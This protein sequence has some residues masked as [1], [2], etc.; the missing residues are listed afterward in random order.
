VWLALLVFIDW[1]S[2]ITKWTDQ[3]LENFLRLNALTREWQRTLNPSLHI[4]TSMCWLRVTE[5]FNW[6]HCICKNCFC[7]QSIELQWLYA[8]RKRHITLCYC[9]FFI[10]VSIFTLD[11][12][13]T[14]A[15]LLLNLHQLS[16]ISSSLNFYPYLLRCDWHF[17]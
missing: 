6:N 8:Y 9:R 4:S 1:I 2:A 16:T 10:N 12:C 17:F 7:F 14:T 11:D 13:M 15:L 5:F 3:L